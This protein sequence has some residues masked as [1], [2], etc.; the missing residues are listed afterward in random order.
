MEE[1]SIKDK[2][3]LLRR[4]EAWIAIEKNVKLSLEEAVNKTNAIVPISNEMKQI[5]RQQ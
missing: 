2:K 5:L 1:V 3:R 4:Y